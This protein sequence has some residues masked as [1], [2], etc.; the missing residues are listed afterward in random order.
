MI[1]L[2][3]CGKQQR[4]LIAGE[5]SIELMFELERHGYIHVASAANCGRAAKQYD[6]A[7]VDWR[8]RTL[9]SLEPTLDWVIDFLHAEGVLVVATD[10]Q[11]AHAR[12]VLNAALETRGFVIE[13]TIVHAGGYAVSARRRAL[14]PVLKAA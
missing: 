2:A 11:K 9:R 6:V 3:H 8:R 5:K 12:A 14:R 10:P 7:L 4:L 13:D 1:A